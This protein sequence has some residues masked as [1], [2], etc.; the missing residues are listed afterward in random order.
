VS[1]TPVSVI[2]AVY[3]GV[4]PAHLVEALASLVDQTRPAAEVLVVADGSLTAE[5]EAVLADFSAPRL[6]LRV[7]RMAVQS[8]SGPARQKAVEAASSGLVA[9]ADADDISLPRR[10]E[11]QARLMESTGAD[12]LGSAVEEFDAETGDVVG[13]RRFPEAPDELRRLLRTRNPINHPTV[14]AR[15]AAVLSAGGYRHLPM[16]E[17]YDLCAR[18][19]ARGGVLANSS[20]VLVRFRGGAASQLRR[21]AKGSLRSEIVLQRNLHEYGVIPLWQVPANVAARMAYR[22]LPT[23]VSRRAYARLFLRGAPK[24]SGGAP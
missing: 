23:S 11:V 24:T 10:F 15:R 1:E 17:D 7:L 3:R 21:R 14:M 13:I 8:G 20:D 2:M 5:L 9:V 18:M 12:L 6:P 19:A 22:M 4:Q 16:L